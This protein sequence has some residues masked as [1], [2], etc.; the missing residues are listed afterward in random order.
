MWLRFPHDVKSWHYVYLCDP[1]NVLTMRHLKNK[2][3]EI[4]IEGYCQAFKLS[5]ATA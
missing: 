3:K 1:P 4:E 5:G 2:L